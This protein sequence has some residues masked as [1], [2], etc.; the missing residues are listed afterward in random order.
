M[1]RAQQIINH[2]YTVIIYHHGSTGLRLPVAVFP[3]LPLS[4]SP[5]LPCLTPSLEYNL[6]TG[7][8]CELHHQFTVPPTVLFSL[9]RSAR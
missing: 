8:Y 5:D 6:D 4:H 7:K 1:R 2:S 3:I 9:L